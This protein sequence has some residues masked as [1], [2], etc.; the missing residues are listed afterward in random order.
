MKS[1]TGP[2]A[3]RDDAAA[4]AAQAQGDRLT[5]CR[6]ARRARCASAAK[7]GL[8]AP[9]RCSTPKSSG[10][11]PAA[12]RRPRRRHRGCARARG[13]CCVMLRAWICGVTHA[14]SC[15][16]LLL[17]PAAAPAELVEPQRRGVAVGELGFVDRAQRGE[18]EVVEVHGQAVVVALDAGRVERA[19]EDAV[20]ADERARRAPARCGFACLI[21]G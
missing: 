2:G 6:T 4:A 14:C 3:A 11:S 16:I 20:G 10:A 8:R 9:L 21:A 15:W 17:R 5:G 13:R 7:D 19:Q 18:R 12:C 1:P